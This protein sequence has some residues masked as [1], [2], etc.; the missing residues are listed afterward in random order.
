MESCRKRGPPGLS[1]TWGQWALTPK[2]LCPKVGREQVGRFEPGSMEK[3]G[4][5]GG[6][7][8]VKS[9]VSED[10]LRARPLEHG[11]LFINK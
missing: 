3:E 8:G 1:V 7:E 5:T 11:S 10:L 9:K 6:M 2:V 4:R